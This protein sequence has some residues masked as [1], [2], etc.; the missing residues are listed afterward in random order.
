[1]IVP[2]CRVHQ[3]RIINAFLVST[4]ME[5][6]LKACLSMT[7]KVIRNYVTKFLPAHRKCQNFAQKFENTQWRLGD[8]YLSENSDL[9]FEIK[10]MPFLNCRIRWWYQKREKNTFI[11]SN[12]LRGTISRNLFWRGGQ[13]IYRFLHILR[14]F[15]NWR[16]QCCIVFVSINIVFWFGISCFEPIVGIWQTK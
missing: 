3:L 7:G 11:L 6:Y 13:R 10:F 15:E 16:E 12:E 1:M 5:L 14:S 2:P 8:A 4:C 9:K